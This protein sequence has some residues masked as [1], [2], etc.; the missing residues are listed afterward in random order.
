MKLIF[1]HLY[2]DIFYQLK[3]ASKNQN[4]VIK[5]LTNLIVRI[6]NQINIS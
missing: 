1:F 3:I 5:D 2:G 4:E 6:F